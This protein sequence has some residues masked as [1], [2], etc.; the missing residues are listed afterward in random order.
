MTK[1]HLSHS[2]FTLLLLSFSFCKA[3]VNYQPGFAILKD[4]TRVSGLIY[5]NENAPWSNQRYIFLKDS[6]AVASNPD[7]KAKKYKADELKYYKVGS[8]EFDKVHYV[9]MA[10]LQL[11]SMGTNDHM[12]E[13]LA[14]GRIKAHRFYSYPADTE[15][16]IGTEEEIAVKQ[17]EKKNDLLTGYKI[18]TQKDNENK[19]HDAFEYDLQKYFEDTPEVAQKY[20]SGAYGNQ[21]VVAKKGLAARMIAMAKKAA[22]KPEEANAII[23]AIN[24]Y[25]NKNTEKN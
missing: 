5:L 3:Q 19:L 20:Q 18:L 22:F 23:A 13:R 25:N 24:D 14:Y 8:R 9:D 4:G 10:N 11:K 6:A 12:L 1:K 2:L 16:Y 21:P 7:V 17:E 15:G